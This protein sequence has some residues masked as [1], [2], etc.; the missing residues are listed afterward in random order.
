MEAQRKKTDFSRPVTMPRISGK[1]PRL[2]TSPG[3]SIAPLPP[4]PTAVNSTCGCASEKRRK[5]ARARSA[6]AL[7]RAP[8]PAAQQA[9]RGCTQLRAR[10]RAMPV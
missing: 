8:P 7:P 2:V 3:S 6:R 4:K 10:A 9:Q 5:R 1:L